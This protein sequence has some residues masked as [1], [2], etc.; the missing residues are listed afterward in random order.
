MRRQAREQVGIDGPQTTYAI[1][2]WDQHHRGSPVLVTG[3]DGKKR[4]IKCQSI[5]LDPDCAK[6]KY[7]QM[8]RGKQ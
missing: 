2:V 4:S 3:A 6:H 8:K 5:E 7:R 1:A